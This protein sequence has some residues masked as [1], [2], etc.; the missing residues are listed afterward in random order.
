M[1]HVN[2]KLLRWVVAAVVAVAAV[3]GLAACGRSSS[4]ESGGSAGI[5]EGAIK[6]GATFPFTGPL[7][8]YGGL[9]KGFESYVSSVNA[10]GGVNGRKIEYTALDDAYDPSRVVA[11]VRRLV[12]NEDNFMVVDFGLGPIS[13]R[14]FV[15]G[16]ETPQ[17]LF[18]GLPYD[19]QYSFTRS[20][21][22]HAA[23]EGE[24]YGRYIAENITDPKVGTLAINNEIAG[25][26]AEGVKTGLGGDAS[27]LVKDIRYEPTEVDL[28]SQINTLRSAGVNALVCIV[29]GTTEIQMLKYIHQIGWHP[30]LFLYSGTVSKQSIFEPAGKAA[31]EGIYSAMWL[32][33]PSDPQW[34]HSS[35]LAGYRADVEK[36]GHGADPSDILVANGYAAAQAVVQGLEEMKEETGKS[37]IEA[38]ESFPPTSLPL[39]QSGVQLKAGPQERL[40]SQYQLLQYD[41]T[42]YRP[43][44]SPQQAPITGSEG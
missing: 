10:K 28:S 24:I 36:Y 4:E 44:G 22:P 11:N 20:W 42:G 5:S 31:T 34:E 37:F 30:K 38:L 13:A 32:K 3:A 12:Q 2:S 35:E 14:P 19:S 1:K 6:I 29:T 23:W 18:G 40:V 26:M 25:A 21:W 17:F 27:D 39:L 43:I 16:T 15:Q 7:A 33:D 41:G 8:V 9:S